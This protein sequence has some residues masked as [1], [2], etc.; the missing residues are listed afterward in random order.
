MSIPLKAIDLVSRVPAGCLT[1]SKN[2]L[3]QIQ[4]ESLSP[5]DEKDTETIFHV[6]VAIFHVFVD[7][8]VLVDYAFAKSCRYCILP[9]SKRFNY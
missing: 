8:H 2:M 9:L 1:T 7:F 6:L 4:A 5:I 3:R